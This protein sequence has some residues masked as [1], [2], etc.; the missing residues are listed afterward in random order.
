MGARTQTRVALPSG[1]RAGR[2]EGCRDLQ[3]VLT[4]RLR[5]AELGQNRPLGISPARPSALRWCVL[6]ARCSMLDSQPCSLALQ[7]FASRER[8]RAQGARTFGVSG[9]EA[10]GP[11]PTARTLGPDARVC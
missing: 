7:L 6:L 2:G 3:R 11:L 1:E 10:W 9:P 8:L 5:R 4:R